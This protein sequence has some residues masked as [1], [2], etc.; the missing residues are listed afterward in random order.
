MC[1]RR[2]QP[3]VTAFVFRRLVPARESGN[4]PLR[5]SGRGGHINDAPIW[6]RDR[7][8]PPVAMQFGPRLEL[9]AHRVA[10]VAAEGQY[11]R[12]RLAHVK[13]DMPEARVGRPA[14]VHCN[15]AEHRPIEFDE[16]RIVAE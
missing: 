3:L 9:I 4:L 13:P 10:L 15:G 14:P 8:G 11:L 5:I 7:F 16:I 2:G 6:D 1:A 12:C